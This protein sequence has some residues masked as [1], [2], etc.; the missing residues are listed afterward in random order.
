MGGNPCDGS[1]RFVS[2]AARGTS[3]SVESLGV[4]S[5]PL[6]REEA[7]AW[8]ET[9]SFTF[10]EAP[11]RAVCDISDGVVSVS[12]S[13]GLCDGSSF[14]PDVLAVTVYRYNRASGEMLSAEV[15]F[16]AAEGL[17]SDEDT[18]RHVALHELGHVLGLAHSD[19][20]GDSGA[21]S[22]M[23]AVLRTSDAR[24]R[25][26]GSDDVAGAEFIY[27]DPTATPT[28]TATAPPT[29]TAAMQSIASQASGGG[30]AAGGGS[31]G[32]V[33]WL[34]AA[35]VAA[36]ARLRLAR[37]VDARRSALHSRAPVERPVQRR[38]RS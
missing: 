19:A 20:C 16:N 28:P 30:C 5:G 37:P 10:V 29:A 36:L 35:F 14:A 8:N 13:D 25:V 26:P 34:L 15:V 12:V 33:A 22:V 31:G 32:T 9:T 17:L 2:W 1:S 7:Q 6:V 21:D 3:F 11:E 27:G 18:F 24:R 38:G 4:V 23:R